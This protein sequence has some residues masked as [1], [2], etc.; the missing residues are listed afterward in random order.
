MSQVG[1]LDLPPPRRYRRACWPWVIAGAVGVLGSA[2]YGGTGLSDLLSRHL[3]PGAVSGLMVGLMVAGGACLLIAALLFGE[4]VT[5]DHVAVEQF[6]WGSP[7]LR[8]LWADV[9]RVVLHKPRR[10]TKGMI[11]LR[12]RGRYLRVDPALLGFD[13][14]EAAILEA[15]GNVGAE[16]TDY[17]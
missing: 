2:A 4:H 8:I 17:R 6:H 16:I 1:P 5:I 13:E 9:N 10:G 11:E 7:P 14:L 15:A 12:G 3:G